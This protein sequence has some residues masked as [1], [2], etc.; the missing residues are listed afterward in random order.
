MRN[1]LYENVYVQKANNFNTAIADGDFP[2]SGSYIDVSDFTH[3]AFLILVGTLDSALVCKVQQATAADGATSDVS[4][5]TLT[6]AADDDNEWKSIE[7]EAAKLNIA[8]DYHFVTLD[9]AGAAGSNDYLC[10]VFQGWNARH[11]PVTQ[12]AGYTE[13]VEVLG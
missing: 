9:V 13:A 8:N 1:N 6:V 11:A 12:P 10:I 5:A 4:G 2:A 7:V 3:F